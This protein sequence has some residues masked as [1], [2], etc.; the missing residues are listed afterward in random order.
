M[1]YFCH[2]DAKTKKKG[3][4][5]LL[6]SSQTILRQS[7]YLVRQHTKKKV[8]CELTKHFFIVLFSFLTYPY[9]DP[10]KMGNK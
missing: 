4:A 2:A 5:V 10:E 7:L 6:N 3:K 1:A 9:F 8:R